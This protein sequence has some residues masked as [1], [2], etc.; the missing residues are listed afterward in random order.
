ML[1]QMHKLLVE[2]LI[3]IVLGQ[4][5]QILSKKEF[6]NLFWSPTHRWQPLL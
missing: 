2:E 6:S 4:Q 3:S 1:P 5:I